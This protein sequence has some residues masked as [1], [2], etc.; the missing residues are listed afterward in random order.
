MKSKYNNKKQGKDKE[1]DN[2]TLNSYA[3]PKYNKVIQAYSLEEAQHKMEDLLQSKA[4]K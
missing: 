1:K 3:F 4:D 2:K